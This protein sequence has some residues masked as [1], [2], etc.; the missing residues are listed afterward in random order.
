LSEALFKM[1]GHATGLDIAVATD[2]LRKEVFTHDRI[3]VLLLIANYLQQNR[4]SD[5]VATFLVDDD[6]VSLLQDQGLDV[7]KCDVAA[8]FRIVQASVRVFLDDSS[9]DHVG[10][11]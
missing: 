7:G 9:S 5:V 3:A 4:P 2:N 8:F 6:K 1:F 10:L 11:W